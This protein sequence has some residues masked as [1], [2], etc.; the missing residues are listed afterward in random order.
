MCFYSYLS[1]YDEYFLWLHKSVTRCCW[2]LFCAL[3]SLYISLPLLTLIMQL[4]ILTR[5][6]ALLGTSHVIEF[7]C[8]DSHH[9]MENWKGESSERRGERPRAKCAFPKGSTIYFSISIF[10]CR[11]TMSSLAF[12]LSASAALWAEC[13]VHMHVYMRARE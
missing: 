4:Q 2:L 13:S 11:L 6:L 12:A 10:S 7:V 5:A 3:I 1:L 8:A 9:T